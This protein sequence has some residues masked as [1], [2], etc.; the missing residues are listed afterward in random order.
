MLQGGIYWS[1][2]EE[3]RVTE[4]MRHYEETEMAAGKPCTITTKSKSKDQTGGNPS[5]WLVKRTG[6]QLDCVGQQ[7]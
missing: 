7:E 5:L 2:K 6:S 4:L 3:Q 1:Q